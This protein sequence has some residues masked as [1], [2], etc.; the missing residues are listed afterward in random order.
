[1]PRVASYF[2][3][4][5][6]KHVSEYNE[7]ELTRVWLMFSHRRAMMRGPQIFSVFP[8]SLLR[9]LGYN[10]LMLQKPLSTQGKYRRIFSPIV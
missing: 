9:G 8:L 6:T 2:T 5:E 1:M 3:F 10:F 4:D 7:S